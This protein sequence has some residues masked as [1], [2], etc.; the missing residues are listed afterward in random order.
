MKTMSTKLMN[1]NLTF[2]LLL[3]V[4]ASTGELKVQ[5]L[6]LRIK[7]LADAAIPSLLL[8]LWKVSMPS[9]KVN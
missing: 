7:D 2:K 5:F 4:L 9:R 3:T 1:K 6:L 8:P